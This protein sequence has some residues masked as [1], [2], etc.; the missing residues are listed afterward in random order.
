[1][2]V[3]RG[4]LAKRQDARADAE[5]MKLAHQACRAVFL[6][7]V[8]K[9]LSMRGI[10]NYDGQNLDVD[11]KKLV[12]KQALAALNLSGEQRKQMLHQRRSYLSTQGQLLQTRQQLLTTLKVKLATLRLIAVL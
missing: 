9:P 12:A 5:I 8:F 1:M 3:L 11:G 7:A 10:I 6:K 4:M 2:D